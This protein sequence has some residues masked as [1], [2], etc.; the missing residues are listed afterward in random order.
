M[1]EVRFTVPGKPRGKGR[2]RFVR[3][4]GRAY[5]PA[6]TASYE[7]LV[8]LAAVAAMNGRPAFTGAV[9]VVVRV[10]L[11]IPASKPRKVQAAM[12]R[13]DILPAKKPDINNVVAAAFDGM[14]GVVFADDRQ[15]THLWAFKRYG[16][17][18][19]EIEVI[20]VPLYGARLETRA[21]A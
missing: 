21:A 6:E 17:P 9:R 12:V 7:N 15:V 10:S 14:N 13:G 20:E 18:G 19:L 11:A 1:S 5:T 8:R 2:P 3:A 4:T 16:T